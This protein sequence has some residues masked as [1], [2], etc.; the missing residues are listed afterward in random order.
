MPHDRG[1]VVKLL[2]KRLDPD[3][4]DKERFAVVLSERAYNDSHD[5]GVFVMIATDPTLGSALG[6]YP[7]ADIRGAG[8]NHASFVVPWLWTLKW[9]KR[10]RP[11]AIGRLSDNEFLSMVECLRQVVSI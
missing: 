11:E 7:I 3:Q 6:S 5:H 1:E 9:S 10:V 4:K 2:A 8:L